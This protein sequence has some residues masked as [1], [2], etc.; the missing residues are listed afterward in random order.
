MPPVPLPAE[1]SLASKCRIVRLV[2]QSETSTV[3]AVETLAK[4]MPLTLGIIHPPA[5]LSESQLARFLRET[6]SMALLPCGP[7]VG[8]SLDRGVEAGEPWW[9]LP[10]LEGELLDA[11]IARSGVLDPSKATLLL[12]SIGRALGDAHRVGIVHGH[13]TPRRIHLLEPPRSD[14]PARVLDFDVARLRHELAPSAD[15][16][17]SLAWL[18][19]AQLRGSS[20][21]TTSDDIWALGLLAATSRGGV[22]A[23]AVRWMAAIDRGIRAVGEAPAPCWRY[24]AGRVLVGPPSRAEAE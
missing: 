24:M 12:L 14:E 13:L 22:T 7:S 4:S 1:S 18:S 2:S 21:P 5:A 20:A 23:A 11:R 19:P 10:E 9:L 8:M 6:A 15:V 17:T 16:A 3:Y